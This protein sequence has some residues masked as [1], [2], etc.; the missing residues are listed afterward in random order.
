LRRGLTLETVSNVLRAIAQNAGHIFGI[1]L[2]A[3][4]SRSLYTTPYLTRY[5]RHA[6]EEPRVEYVTVMES[7]NQ[8][9]GA[10]LISVVLVLSTFLS[11]ERTLLVGVL[12]AAPASFGT[13]LIR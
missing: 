5:Y 2:L 12:L 8:L 10:I 13:R 11:V 1:N 6:D 3:G 9:G 4:V 7:A